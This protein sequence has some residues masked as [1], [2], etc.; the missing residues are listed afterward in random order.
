MA[1]VYRKTV[2][3]PIPDNAE[4]IERKGDL[5]VRFLAKGERKTARVVIGKDGQVVLGKDG[6]ERMSMK[7]ETFTA[8]YRDHL[9]IVR[10]VATRCRHEDAAKH[11]LK[12]IL[13]RE[14][15]LKAGVITSDESTIGK[16]QQITTAVHLAAYLKSMASAGITPKH[17]ADTQQ[18]IERLLAECKFARLSDIR[19]EPMESWLVARS[20]EGLSARTRN[21]YLQA[22]RTFLKWCIQTNRL[23]S[24]PLS[25]VAKADQ[26]SDRRKQRRAMTETEIGQLLQVAL[27]R[28]LAEYGR[29]TI[30]GDSNKRRSNWT[31]ETLSLET[32]EGCCD[33]ARDRLRGNPAFVDELEQRGYERSLVYKVFIL[34]GLRCNELRSITLG[35]LHLADATPCIELH[36]KDEKNRQGSTLPL[37][38]ELASELREWIE[39]TKPLT[40]RYVLKTGKPQE[41]RPLFNVP[42]GLLKILDRDLA[43]AG[44]AKTDDRGRSL[45]VHALRTTFGTMLSQAGVSPR[46]AQAAMRHSRIDLTMN[47]YTDPKLLD[48]AGAVE[49]LPSLSRLRLEPSELMRATGTDD[50]AKKDAPIVA[51]TFGNSCQKL[52][53]NGKNYAQT[54]NHDGR[55]IRSK[56]LKIVHKSRVLLR[57]I[58]GTRTRDLRSHNPTL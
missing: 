40:E 33:R 55:Q 48:V 35:Q 30:A 25:R 44:I 3:R 42:D 15:L 22:I 21:G 12:E 31:Y 18:K 57:V 39:R 24:N 26:K 45:D 17:I 27:W 49:S 56:P 6:Q 41:T 43:T 20:D 23:N 28:P 9:G 4:R 19:R 53:S 14:E 52:S 58:D 37:C 32:L 13:R 1:T 34:T 11:V 8:K 2:T 47:V 51:P 38:S 46:T 5:F 10:E 54:E 7:A 16:Q 50:H 36:A 29:K